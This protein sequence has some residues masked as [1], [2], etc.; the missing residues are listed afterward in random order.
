M[1]E[2]DTR[3]IRLVCGG[4]GKVSRD[5]VGSD[6]TLTYDCWDPEATPGSAGYFEHLFNKVIEYAPLDLIGLQRGDISFREDSEGSRNFMFD[7]QYQSKVPADSL[8]RWSFDTSGGTVLMKASKAT[9]TYKVASFPDAPNLRG[10][11]GVKGAEVEGCEVV[12]PLLKLT[13]TYRHLQFTTPPTFPP[14]TRTPGPVSDGTIDAYIK[15]LAR[16]TGRTNQ[17]TWKTYLQGE[18]LFLGATGEY[19]P[20]KDTEI[21]YHFAAS[22]NTSSLTIGQITGIVKRGHEYLWIAFRATDSSGELVPQPRYCYVE[23]VYDEFNFSDLEI[24]S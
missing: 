15:K 10:A 19:V 9:R 7:V 13:A 22:E 24:G 12:T 2:E 23:R 21:Q 14:T 20:G 6:L 16:L 3:R 11:I 1:P 5:G 18:L 4:Q 17:T 8:I